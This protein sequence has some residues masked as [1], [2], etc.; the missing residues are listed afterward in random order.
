MEIYE[1]VYIHALA[2]VHGDVKIGYGSSIWPGAVLRADYNS[3][4]IGRYSNVQDNSVIHCTPFK[5]SRVGDWVTIGHGCILHGMTVGD[6]VVVGMGSIV[7]DGVTAGAGS[8]IAAG[9]LV[10]EGL[11]IPPD[12]FVSGNPAKI[13]PARPGTREK[14]KLGALT[15]YLLSR[16]YMNGIYTFPANELME[17]IKQWQEK[18]KNA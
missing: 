8:F 15:Y 13:K 6:D 18:N 3:I 17:E 10:P 12:S 4:T 16:R 14:Y 11:D 1:G 5:P 7:L 9:T 2:A